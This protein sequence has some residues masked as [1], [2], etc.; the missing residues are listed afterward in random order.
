MLVVVVLVVVLLLFLGLLF[1]VLVVA[2]APIQILVWPIDIPS[3][4]GA[5]A[6]GRLRAIDSIAPAA[7]HIASVHLGEQQAQHSLSVGPIEVIEFDCDLLLRLSGRVLGLKVLLGE[8][9]ARLNQ[10]KELW[11]LSCFLASQIGLKLTS[12]LFFHLFH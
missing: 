9:A 7:C 12:L 11:L 1:P 3:A 4:L 5:A 6:A 2:E 10:R 8:L